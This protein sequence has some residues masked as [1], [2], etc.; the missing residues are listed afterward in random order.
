MNYEADDLLDM[1]DKWKFKLHDKLKKLTPRQRAAFWQDA[2]D[3]ARARGL[4]VAGDR[5]KQKPPQ[6]KAPSHG[7]TH[8]ESRQQFEAAVPST[9]RRMVRGQQSRQIADLAFRAP[10]GDDRLEGR[11]RYRSEVFMASRTYRGVVRQGNVLVLEK[12]PLADGTEVLVTPVV[13]GQGT[14][15]ALLTALDAAPPVPA[16]W[17]DELEQLIAQGQ[18]PPTQDDPFTDMP[19][20]LEDR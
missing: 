16:A 6:T 3:Q 18:R 4:P 8:G 11:P 2:I 12:M 9:Q 17:V 20:S 15:A 14:A 5:A 7:M 19:G 13:N 1:V 10:G